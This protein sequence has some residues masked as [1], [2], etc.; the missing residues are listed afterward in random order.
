MCLHS[1]P[2]HEII[3][4]AANTEHHLL[5]CLCKKIK[6]KKSKETKTSAAC[7][8]SLE[9]KRFSHHCMA[10][11][12][13]KMQFPLQLPSA[14]LAFAEDTARCSSSEHS[15]RKPLIQP[16]AAQMQAKAL[17]QAENKAWDFPCT[18][19]AGDRATKRLLCPGS[20]SCRDAPWK[21]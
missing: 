11:C 13:H 14:T 17:P 18:D 15:T 20:T 19:R 10:T 7:T 3:F 2:P 9:G 21:R 1:V 16:P 8:N 5:S 4:P 12:F 6:R